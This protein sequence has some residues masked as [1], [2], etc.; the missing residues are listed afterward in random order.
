MKVKIP[1]ELKDVKKHFNKVQKGVPKA[2]SNALNRAASSAKTA[3]VREVRDT[4][5]IKAKDINKT[6]RLGRAKGNNLNVR[7][8]SRGGNTPL[9]NFKTRPSKPPKR[10]PKVLR[11]SVKKG[12]FKPITGAFVTRA[13]Q[14]I[15]VFARLGKKRLPI[16][17]KYG[18]AAPVMLSQEG[19]NA[20]FEGKAQEE[21]KK[22]LDHEMNRLGGIK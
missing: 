19:V 16:Q 12:R 18:P 9:I 13:G 7:L 5:T 4:Y 17:E 1:N 20:R 10:Q 22:R 8:T 3:A 6:L 2:V 11:A 15:G 21:F 14:H